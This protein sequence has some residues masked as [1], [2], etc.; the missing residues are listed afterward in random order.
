M[1]WA[2]IMENPDN[3]FAILFILWGILGAWY[4]K[5]IRDEEKHQ[6]KEKFSLLEDKINQLEK[7]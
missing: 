2:G 1:G 7:K 3:I 5:T 6:N 4:L